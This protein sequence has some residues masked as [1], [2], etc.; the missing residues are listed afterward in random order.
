VKFNPNGT[1]L[2]SSS[3]DSTARVWDIEKGKC[4]FELKGH[5]G[6]VINLEHNYIGD[7]MITC[8]FDKNAIIWDLKTGQ[9]IQKLEGHNG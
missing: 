9:Q 1:Y 8:S 3:L 2:C 4:I 5:E 7:Q 6:E